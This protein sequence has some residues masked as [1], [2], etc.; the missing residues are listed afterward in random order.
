MAWEEENRQGGQR[1]AGCLGSPQEVR[2]STR[3]AGV[4]NMSMPEL[5][6]Q[7][8]LFKAE[9]LGAHGDGSPM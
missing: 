2:L 1:C 7:C 8:Q 4:T 5:W 6:V 9:F 3:E